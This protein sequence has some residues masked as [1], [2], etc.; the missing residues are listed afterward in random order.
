MLTISRNLRDLATRLGDVLDHVVRPSVP[1]SS[2]NTIP[3]T[4]NAVSLRTPVSADTD[5]GDAEEVI[6]DLKRPDLHGARTSVSR[7]NWVDRLGL[8]RWLL[9]RL[10]QRYR[11]MQHHFPFVLIP[12]AWNFQYML[13]H[14]PVLLLAVVSSSACHYPRIQKMLIKDLKD[15]LSSRVMVGGENSLE[16]LQ[17]ILVHLAWYVIGSVIT[18]LFAWTITPSQVTIPHDTTEPTDL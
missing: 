16:L 15:I 13:T 1:R 18:C 3:E 12:E 14:R 17:A 11:T 9:G 4:S 10:L 5:H 6:I 8:D 7:E 2:V